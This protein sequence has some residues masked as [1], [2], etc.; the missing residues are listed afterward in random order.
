[1]FS[2]ESSDIIQFELDKLAGNMMYKIQET[3]VFVKLKLTQANGD[4]VPKNEH[5]APINNVGHS[6]FSKVEL[7]INNQPL[8]TANDYYAQ[9]AYLSTLLGSTQPQQE[10]VL[11]SAG[12]YKEDANKFNFL[13]DSFK[14]RQSRFMERSPEMKKAKKYQLDQYT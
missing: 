4:R 12:F 1:M 9:R 10:G 2:I 8:T 7:L 14:Q 6:M 5:V 13:S 3:L 11:Q